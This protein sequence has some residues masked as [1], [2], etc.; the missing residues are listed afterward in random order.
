[1]KKISLTIDNRLSF[2]IEKDKLFK[3]AKFFYDNKYY[4]QCI[5]ILSKIIEKDNENYESIDLRA[6]CYYN[7][8]LF[9]HSKNDLMFLQEKNQLSE[10]GKETLRM[11]IRQE[12]TQTI[13]ASGKCP[14]CD[15]KIS[16]ESEKCPN[17]G[18]DLILK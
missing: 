14:I 5:Q 13:K 8:S 6:S 11:I 1:K 4:P 15:F 10:K 18:T 2:E 3:K 12:V 7:M 17:C 9:E 16:E